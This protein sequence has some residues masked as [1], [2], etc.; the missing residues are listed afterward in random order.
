MPGWLKVVSHVN[1]LTYEV[2]GLRALMLAY[3]T[4]DYGFRLDFAVLV[5]VTAGRMAIAVRMYRR[6]GY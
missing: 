1:P 4:S 2:D 5:A 6:M 3:G